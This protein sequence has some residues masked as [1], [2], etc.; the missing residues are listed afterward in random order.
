MELP[1]VNGWSA[2]VVHEPKA[3]LCHEGT[4]GL[5]RGSRGEGLD[6]LDLE[7]EPDRSRRVRVC[8]S[9]HTTK[10]SIIVP[11]SITQAVTIERERKPGDHDQVGL[12]D[13]EEDMVSRGFGDAEGALFE[14]SSACTPELQVPAIDPWIKNDAIARGILEIDRLGLVAH[15]GIKRDDLG[16]LKDVRL[17]E[18]ARGPVCEASSV[19]LIE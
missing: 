3:R 6:D 2:R 15:R 14:L 7:T 16:S 10:S 19:V 17:D 12:C 5:V 4:H 1:S 13:L 18:C 9:A 11:A 8:K